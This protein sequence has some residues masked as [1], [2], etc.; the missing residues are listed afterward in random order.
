[1]L[2]DPVD[3]IFGRGLGAYEYWEGRGY[4]Y[5]TELTYLELVRNFGL[6]GAV[7]MLGLLLFPIWHAFVA[8][9]S[10]GRKAVAIGFAFYLGMCSSNPNLF[11]SMGILILSVVLGILFLPKTPRLV[12]E[13]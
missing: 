4:K 6:L 9:R 12:A 1:M 7:V 2:S 11:S 3:L 10:R 5:V 13:R 8:N